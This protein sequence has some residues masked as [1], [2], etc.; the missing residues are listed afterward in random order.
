[1][2]KIFQYILSEKAVLNIIAVGISSIAM[3]IIYFSFFTNNNTNSKI[4]E[5]AK[6]AAANYESAKVTGEKT[7]AI[8]AL[9]ALSEIRKNESIQYTILSKE[10]NEISQDFIDRAKDIQKSGVIADL[11]KPRI[12]SK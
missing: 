1:M 9:N 4:E 2:K 10:A 3:S 8:S 7:E 5:A 11:Q 6:N 12:S